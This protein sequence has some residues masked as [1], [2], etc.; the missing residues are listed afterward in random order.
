MILRIA[1]AAVAAYVFSTSSFAATVFSDDFNTDS[2]AL[3]QTSFLGGWTVS[4]GTVDLIGTGFFDFY[5][6]NGHYVDLDGSTANAGVFSKSG[7]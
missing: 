6:G 3:N 2:L 1:L 5:P 4:S 7:C